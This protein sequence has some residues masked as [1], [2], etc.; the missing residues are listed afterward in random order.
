MRWNDDDGGDGA[1]LH[2][3][4][5]DSYERANDEHADYDGDDVAIDVDDAD[6]ATGCLRK[7]GC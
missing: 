4:K 5:R 6:D 1:A 3:E 2:Y 7:P